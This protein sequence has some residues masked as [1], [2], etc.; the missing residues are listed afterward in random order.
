M[1]AL[2]KRDKN[3]SFVL[4]ARTGKYKH[5][6]LVFSSTFIATVVNWKPVGACDP[7]TRFLYQLQS[8]F[9]RKYSVL[10][11]ACGL[12]RKFLVRYIYINLHLAISLCRL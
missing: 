12:L 10:R 9:M 3:G 6:A 2:P 11:D 7:I 1:I 4:L 5:S 8:N